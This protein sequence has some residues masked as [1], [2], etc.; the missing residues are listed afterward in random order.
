MH[1]KDTWLA[2]HLQAFSIAPSLGPWQGLHSRAMA[3]PDTLNSDGV[4]DRGYI[5]LAMLVTFTFNSN[6]SNWYGLHLI[7]L[8]AGCWPRHLQG[9]GVTRRMEANR[10]SKELAGYANATGTDHHWRLNERVGWLFS[11][12]C[13]TVY[14]PDR[15][16]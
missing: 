15:D 11:Q 12:G 2:G 3:V 10:M 1:C 9:G 14:A 5:Q 6:G 4:P 13:C 8:W 16:L 7:A